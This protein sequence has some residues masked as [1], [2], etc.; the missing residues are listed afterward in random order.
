MT[1]SGASV[2]PAA[3]A[4]C[5]QEDGGGGG[6]A[7][8]GGKAALFLGGVLTVMQGIGACLAVDTVVPDGDNSHHPLDLG[9]FFAM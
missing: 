7:L 3:V 9:K 1:A 5:G 8:R 4:V 2:E 6:H